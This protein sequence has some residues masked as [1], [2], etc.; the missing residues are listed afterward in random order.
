M[1]GVFFY[2]KNGEEV[3]SKEIERISDIIVSEFKKSDCYSSQ[4]LWPAITVFGQSTDS[5]DFNTFP[6]ELI[7]SQKV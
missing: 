6:K 2:R 7:Y 4:D 5:E 1:G 3:R